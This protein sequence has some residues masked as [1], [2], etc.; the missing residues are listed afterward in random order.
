MS[1]NALACVV[2]AP[3]LTDRVRLRLQELGRAKRFKQKDVADAMGFKSPSAVTKVLTGDSRSITLKFVEVCA[4]AA[5]IPLAELVSDPGSTVRELNPTEAK[6][7]RA[8]RQWPESVTDALTAFVGF[9]ADEPPAALQTRNL[10]EHWRRLKQLDRDYVELL[11][12]VLSQRDVSPEVRALL[13]DRLTAG[14]AAAS[15]RPGAKR[16]HTP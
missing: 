3:T 15:K 14:V 10:H 5:G 4:R 7:L 8:L 11:A 2:S 9:F 13:T 16:D 1:F 12:R 6:L